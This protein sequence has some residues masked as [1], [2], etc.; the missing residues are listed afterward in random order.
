[1]ILSIWEKLTQKMRDKGLV[2]WFIKLVGYTKVIGQR[3]SGT[4]KV[5]RNTQIEIL[6]KESSIMENPMGRASIGG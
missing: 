1:M 3:T 4:G 2:L 5:T 6:M